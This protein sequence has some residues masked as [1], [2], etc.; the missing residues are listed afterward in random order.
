[1][2]SIILSGCG[3]LDYQDLGGIKM[4]WKEHREYYDFNYL[5]R[6][7]PN[8]D[9]GATYSAI[10]Q[11]LVDLFHPQRVLDC[12]C[13]FGWLVNQL[14][15]KG[16]EAYGIDVNVA[17][18]EHGQKVYPHIKERL[19]SIDMATE[20]IPFPDKH[21]DLVIAR[22]LLEHIS[23]DR[24]FYTVSE[25]ARVS[26]THL[27]ITSPMVRRPDDVSSK[28]WIEW[29]KS[30]N[31]NSLQDNIDLIDKHPN[32]KS[33]YPHPFAIEHPNTHC[34][35]FWVGLFELIGFRQMFYGEEPYR[36][37]RFDN[38]SGFGVLDFMLP[39]N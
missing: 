12:G 27:R 33:E 18:I 10:A 28:D 5:L 9:F 3:M 14:H 30:L 38:H 17:S 26:A 23:D 20:R 19:L 34:R 4:N 35:D 22:E 21:F 2:N 7:N 16:I 8:T 13:A 1:M 11:E 31:N 25:I 36:P 39:S 29:L 32:L 24:F 15:I 6:Q 37:L